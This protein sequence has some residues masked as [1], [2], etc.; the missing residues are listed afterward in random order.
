MDEETPRLR[1]LVVEDESLVA[2]LLEDML[3][4]MGCDVVA[5]AARLAEGLEA[6][7]R[8]SFDVAFLDVN[9][10]GGDR[11]FA[12][13]RRLEERGLPFAFL[14]AYGATPV[15][16]EFPAAPVVLKPF[17]KHDLEKALARTV[18]G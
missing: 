13:A 1:I 17:L 8:E 15:R 9:L 2:F 12:I 7:E 5:S 11:S 14:T 6:A 10:G 18:G 4:E 16:D 3:E